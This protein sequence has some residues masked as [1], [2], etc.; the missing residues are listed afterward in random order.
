MAKPTS[1]TGAA[2]VSLFSLKTLLLSVL[3]GCLQVADTFLGT[4]YAGVNCGPTVLTTIV[5]VEDY[6]LFYT[7]ALPI[8]E[9]LQDIGVPAFFWFA[10]TGHPR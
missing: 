5:H 4:H 9:A 7:V 6:M 8:A 1:V 3:M 10:P 2:T